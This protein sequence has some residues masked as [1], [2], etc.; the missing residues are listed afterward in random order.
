MPT[1]RFIDFA[2]IKAAVKIEQILQHYALLDQFTH[3]N[4]SLSG[5]CP[6]HRGTNP[7]QFRV[8]LSKN[9]WNCFGDC[10][11]GGNV[12]D[13]V[14]RIERISP[15]EAANRLV[16]WFQ[17]DVTQMN[18]ARPP[19]SRPPS[20]SKPHAPE[21]V[22]SAKPRAQPV[23]QNEVLPPTP[24]IPQAV[25]SGSVTAMPPSNAN[26]PLGFSLAE[27]LDYSHPYLMERGLDEAAIHEFGVGFCNAG[28]LIARIAI[29]IHNAQGELI[30]YAGR[31]PGDPPKETPKYKLPKGFKK[32]A[33]VFNLHRAFRE[34]AEHALI[35]V[36]GF[37]DVF[38]LWQLG[39][40]RVVAL[41]GSSLSPAQ[42]AAL[43]T[44][45][46]S[47]GTIA[48]LF[49]EDEAGRAGRLEALQRLANSAFVRVIVLPREGMQPEHLDTATAA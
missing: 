20:V 2:A 1:H 40:R 17:L 45:V 22:P 29:P 43:I 14:E 37:F 38:R 35:V 39:Y 25:P 8:S 5:P 48:L 28:T 7:T 46:R 47:T 33:E 24:S 4:D 9:C 18:A 41:M 42:E 6:I 36:E 23:R 10:K 19:R 15:I 34:P 44:A 30:A 21:K 16:E 31:W 49:D 32:S 26:R 13:L 27:K 11:S 3:G 12:L